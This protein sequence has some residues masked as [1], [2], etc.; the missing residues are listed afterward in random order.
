[1]DIEEDYGTVSIREAGNG[2]TARYQRRWVQRHSR[3]NII[4]ANE[5]KRSWNAVLTTYV[6]SAGA[7]VFHKAF[8]LDTI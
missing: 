5:A 7:I 4:P 1:M 3:H 2:K 8:V 6:R